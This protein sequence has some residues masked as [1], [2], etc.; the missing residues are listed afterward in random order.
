M[1]SAITIAAVGTG[2]SAYNGMQAN[3]NASKA[4]SAQQQAQQNDL[5]FRQQQYNRYLGLYGPVEEQLAR[6]AQSSSPLDYERNAA[7][8]KAQYADALRNISG[9]MGMRGI[10][11][12]GQDIGAMRN[13][14]LGQAGALSEAYAKGLINRRNLGLQLTGRGDI[15]HAAGGLEGGMQNLSNFYGNQAGL[16]GGAAQNSWQ[17]F[18]AGLAG[19][20]SAIQDYRNAPQAPPYMTNVGMGMNTSGLPTGSNNMNDIITEPFK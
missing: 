12:S 16:F 18:G 20:G 2:L 4:M 1:S 17:N 7:Q 14:A 15:Q 9:S 5:A 3:S 11:G 6:E 10:A 8:I 13:A 19:L